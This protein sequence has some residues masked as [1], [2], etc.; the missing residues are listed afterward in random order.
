MSFLICAYEALHLISPVLLHSFRRQPE[1]WETSSREENSSDCFAAH[2]REATSESFIW[3]QCKER[4]SK[5]NV[6]EAHRGLS[7]TQVGGVFP[8]EKLKSCSF[9]WRTTMLGNIRF[10]LLYYKWAAS[11]ALNPQLIQV[12]QRL[13]LMPCI[14]SS[15]QSPCGTLMLV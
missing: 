8:V 13:Q 4:K 10:P 9:S 3:N 1:F 14:T 15:L 7:P 6:N 5:V 12:E 2:M 11:P